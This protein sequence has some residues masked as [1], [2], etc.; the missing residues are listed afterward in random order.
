MFCAFPSE[1][2]VF[3]FLWNSVDGVLFSKEI[4]DGNRT[5]WSPVRSVIIR[6]I[7]KSVDRATRVRMITDRT[8]R[9]EI[10]I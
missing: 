5:E 2:Y 8:G 7:T 3:K 1:T 9:H 10:C 4:S 6:V